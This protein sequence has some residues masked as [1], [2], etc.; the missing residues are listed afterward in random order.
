MA[1][2]VENTSN[3]DQFADVEGVL[4]ENWSDSSSRPS[5]EKI[6]E[7]ESIML[8]RMW[9][10]KVEK[11]WPRQKSQNVF[12]SC[13]LQSQIACKLTSCPLDSNMVKSVLS[14]RRTLKLRSASEDETG[15]TKSNLSR[16]STCPNSLRTST[17]NPRMI[18]AA[19]A[20]LLNE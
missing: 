1:K 7:C 9:S 11:Q 6:F 3:I 8:E 2:Y 15:T 13:H 19:S 16:F 5:Q 20:L 10:I 4:L 17:G 12:S 14:L 18:P